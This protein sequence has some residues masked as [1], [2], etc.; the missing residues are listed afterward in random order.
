M[1]SRFPRHFLSAYAVNLMALIP[2]HWFIYLLG[3]GIPLIFYINIDGGPNADDSGHYFNIWFMGIV[4]GALGVA[5]KLAD[6][7]NKP[8]LY[9][10]PRQQIVLRR[11][12]FAVGLLMSAFFFALTVLPEYAYWAP[13]TTLGGILPLPIGLMLYLVIV[14]IAIHN[15]ALMSWV[16]AVLM[17]GSSLFVSVY[18]RGSG[19]DIVRPPEEIFAFLGLASVIV[20]P[21][22]WIALGRKTLRRELLGAETLSS[23]KGDIVTQ[24]EKFSLFQRGPHSRAKDFSTTKAGARLLTKISQTSPSSDY[25]PFLSL[26]YRMRSSNDPIRILAVWLVLSVFAVFLSLKIHESFS[27]TVLLYLFTLA[28]MFQGA[29]I[30]RKSFSPFLPLG[31]RM[32][33]RESLYNALLRLALVIAVFLAIHGLAQGVHNLWPHQNWSAHVGDV[34]QLPLKHY[35]F[36]LFMA[37]LML[38][39]FQRSRA[40][41]W[42][43]FAAIISWITLYNA[44][45]LSDA[46]A[47]IH[48]AAIMCLM[49]M[50]WLPFIALN[51]LRAYKRD[52]G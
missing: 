11:I 34:L 52:L 15:V 27:P 10:M 51:Y 14:S 50:A 47:K 40:P 22:T 16:T 35:L 42:L 30:F 23:E 8:A 41:S 24:L 17:I 20:I 18:F 1:E 46:F 9:C 49:I 19:P 29:M 48:I 31:R 5:F 7:L 25:R 13:P 28:A 12:V 2:R 33:F 36:C 38:F 26:F 21:L 6:L 3:I 43:L 45:T 44:P 39:V 37:P 32:Y 4:Y